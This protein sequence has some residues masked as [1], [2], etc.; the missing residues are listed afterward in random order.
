MIQAVAFVAAQAK[1]CN[2]D[3]DV[4]PLPGERP[5]RGQSPEP[6]PDLAGGIVVTVNVT[7][8]PS[9][10][11]TAAHVVQGSGSKPLDDAAIDAA[12]KSQ[13]TPKMVDCR[14]VAGL[15]LFKVTFVPSV[16]QHQR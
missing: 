15:Y 5:K 10:K 14:A 7:V 11:P 9:G 6:E 8:D 2:R 1:S 4:V 12:L 13:Y 3:A 16:N